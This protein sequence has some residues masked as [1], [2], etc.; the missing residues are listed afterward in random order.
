MGRWGLAGTSLV[1]AL[2]AGLLSALIIQTFLQSTEHLTTMM[3]VLLG[4]TLACSALVTL[5]PVAI[6]VFY[7]K[8]APAAVGSVDAS[9]AGTAPASSEE[10]TA[11][12][13]PESAGEQEDLEPVEDLD[14]EEFGGESEPE[15]AG[16]A[17]IFEEGTESEFDE[18]DADEFDD[19]Q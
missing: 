14:G 6:L 15:T 8:T 3:T 4:F 16:E 9:A 11:A 13:E 7:P 18:F 19:E 5:L 2:F 12:L 1:G 17:D 10:G